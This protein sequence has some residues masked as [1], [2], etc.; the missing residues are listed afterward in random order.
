MA[1]TRR[2]DHNVDPVV[3]PS[4]RVAES[5]DIVQPSPEHRL[6]SL[7]HHAEY[8]TL[9]LMVQDSSSNAACM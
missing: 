1:E 4:A 8:C 9:M 6:V 2:H 5:H 7:L 3:G